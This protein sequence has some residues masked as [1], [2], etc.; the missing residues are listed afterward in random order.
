MSTFVLNDAGRPEV[1]DPRAEEC[2]PL[3]S[4]AGSAEYNVGR[5][6][7]GMQRQVHDDLLPQNPAAKPD[8]LDLYVPSHG[9][10][11][12]GETS[13]MYI[14]ILAQSCGLKPCSIGSSFYNFTERYF[15]RGEGDKEYDKHQVVST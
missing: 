3:F 12:V 1:G 9:Y 11:E 2:I 10:S 13:V 6:L 4:L 8:T 7:D 5:L 15:E 14:A